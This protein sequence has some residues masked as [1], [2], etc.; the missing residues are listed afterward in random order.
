MDDFK[1]TRTN[2]VRSLKL[3][4]DEKDPQDQKIMLLAQL[5]EERCNS[6][7]VN[8]VALHECLINTDKKLDALSELLA[9]LKQTEDG[10]PILRNKNSSEALIF[11]F[12]HPRILFIFITGIV[13]II[14]GMCGLGI[15]D[16]IKLL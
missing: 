2:V 14:A 9:K 11:L 10:C 5:M 3:L 4:C 13:A 8:Q 6:L 12:K 16:L 1:G 15:S 7:E